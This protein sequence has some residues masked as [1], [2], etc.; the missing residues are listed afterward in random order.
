M[1][2]R[3]A[4]YQIVSKIGEGGM[5]AVYRATDTK[6]NRDVAIKVLPDSFASD[7]DRLARFTREAQVLAS[8][9][10]PNIATI[11]GIEERAIVMELIEGPTL[12]DRM[13]HGAVP[14]EEALAIARQIAEALEAAH[15]KNVVHRD[16]KPANVKVTPEGI[17]KVLDFGLAKLTDPRE[18]SENPQS[19]PTVVRGHSPTI[20][21]MIMGTAEYM[22]PEQAA[23]KPVDKRTDIWAFGVMLWEMLSGRGLFRGESVS[24]TLADVLR[25]P[26]DFQELPKETPPAIR[27]LIKR[28][29]DRDLKRRLRDVG[30]ARIAIGNAGRPDQTPDSPRASRTDWLA[31]GMAG[32]MAIAAASAWL[33]PFRATPVTS[34]VIRFS[35]P[36]PEGAQ[37]RSWAEVSPDGKYLVYSTFAGERSTIW[38]RPLNSHQAR[39]L[40]QEQG[41]IS[42]PFWSPDSRWIA[43]VTMAKFKKVEVAS[44]SPSALTIVDLLNDDRSYRGGTWNRDGVLL[45]APTPFSG[46]FRINAAGGTRSPVTTIDER[47]ENGHTFPSFLPD[48]NH[49]LYYVMS[50]DQ[51]RSGVYVGDLRSGSAARRI[52]DSDSHAIFVPRSPGSSSGHL[53]YSKENSLRAVSFDAKRLQLSGEPTVLG[54]GVGQNNTHG[55][56]SA[57]A[58]GVLGYWAGDAFQPLDLNW[59]RRDGKLE[60]PASATATIPTG[61]L[62]G[63]SLSPDNRQLS[64]SISSPAQR[65]RVWLMG[66]IQG[67]FRPVSPEKVRGLGPIWSPDSRRLAFGYS[68][69]GVLNVVIQH[70]D[71]PFLPE[72]VVSAASNTW[73]R[74]WSQD[75]NLLVYEI[76]P[77]G[78]RALWGMSLSNKKAHEWVKGTQG[79]VAPGAANPWWM[80]YTSDESGGNEIFLESFTLEGRRA[81]RARISVNGGSDP[82]WRADGRELY[83]ISSDG[84][85]TAVSV[86]PGFIP[87]TPKEMFAMPG[88][89]A[90]SIFRSHRYA[91]TRDAQRFL[92]ATYAQ[93]KQTEPLSVVVNWQQELPH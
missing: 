68:E 55:A 29:L 32:L 35:I 13:G 11:F 50:A 83:Y 80:A 33:V 12:A 34:D 75:G 40:V 22:S 58:N 62:T 47:L 88:L 91:V 54:N 51:G 14:L 31:W 20:A 69:R 37:F 82:R 46:V 48:G 36:P 60:G 44:A 16:L 71:Q 67:G 57:S 89:P 9:N 19:A 38:V 76:D 72:P 43:Y 59:Y 8:L 65:N 7:P 24:H 66:L 28:C 70:L 3:I 23:G 61:L 1:D 21:G 45:F 74:D 77:A 73:P 25:A 30:E 79:Q 2:S 64:I 53:L 84:K 17:V 27:D 93:G 6:L 78:R 86:G 4:H 10:H 85:L 39:P 87:T 15:E 49:F 42:Y 26:I 5:G 41:R 18:A 92:I 56:F 90:G 63:F 81:G 52:L